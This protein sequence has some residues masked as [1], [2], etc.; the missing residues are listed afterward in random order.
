[1]Q[2][3]PQTD[4]PLTGKKILVTRPREQAS[5]FSA[6]LREYGAEPIEIPTIQIDAPSSWQPLDQAITAIRAYDWLVFTSVNGVQAFFLRFE[7]LGRRLVEL[8]GLKLCAIGPETAKHLRAHGVQVDVVPAEY[9]AEA[10]VEALSQ[11]PLQGRRVLIPRASVAREV[12]PRALEAQGAQVEV[13][14]AYRTVLPAAQVEPEVRRLLEQRAIAA[15]TFTSSS[16]VANFAALVGGTIVPHLLHGVV[17]A[18][19][20][21]I[22]AETARS[23]GL[24][25]EILPKEYTI[26]ALARAIAEYFTKRSAVSDQRSAKGG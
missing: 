26:P 10:V 25:P 7:Q 23:Y 21:P 9:R 17:V 16:T 14:E 24:T 11:F 4:K 18:C 1:M 20:G 8:Q 13:V 15:V 5:R 19:I 2:T 22:T 12:L 3:T 6:L